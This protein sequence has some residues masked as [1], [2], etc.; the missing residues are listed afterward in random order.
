MGI[1]EKLQ[2]IQKLSQMNQTELARELGVS[3][4]AFN[5]WIN[6][7]ATP[8]KGAQER[9]DALYREYTGLT[10]IPEDALTAKKSML[11]H[12]AKKATSILRAIQNNPDIRDELILQLTYTSN[13]IEGST[14]DEAETAAVLFQNRALPQKTLVE[15]LEAKNHQFVLLE[16][17][18]L[19]TKKQRLHEEEILALHGKL[20]NGIHSDAGSYR[21]HAVRIIGAH[22]PTANHLKIPALMQELVS[23]MHRG[24]TD[25]IE[26]A[27]SIHARFEQIHPFADG[28]G[29]IGRL[30]LHAMLLE[31]NH[32]P[33]VMEPEKKHIYYH[34]LQRAQ[35]KNDISLLEDFLCDSMQLSWDIVERKS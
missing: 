4:V 35:L 23:D 14:L 10:H 24:S 31:Q 13:S 19:C 15:Q 11:V 18:E 6:G 17:F 12:R 2:A 9:I 34:A 3:F 8:R 30:L 32:P 28:N 20:L 1:P 26:H 25:C 7:K 21:R 22:V 29:R 5:R 16:L 33:A 27:A